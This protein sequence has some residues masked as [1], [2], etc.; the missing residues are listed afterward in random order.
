MDDLCDNNQDAPP[1]DGSEVIPQPITVETPGPSSSKPPDG[2]PTV[3]PEQVLPLPKAAP[4]RMVLQGV[5]CLKQPR[6]RKKKQPTPRKPSKKRRVIESDSDYEPLAV[7]IEESDS[8]A[9]QENNGSEYGDEVL[10]LGIGRFVLVKFTTKTSCVRYIVEILEKV[11]VLEWKLDFYAK[12]AQGNFI[13]PERL[14]ISVMEES[15]ALR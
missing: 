7:L 15:Q 11:D 12:T 13:K 5:K 8:D 14:D 4:G 1:E 6:R 9:E 10:E 2:L 3:T